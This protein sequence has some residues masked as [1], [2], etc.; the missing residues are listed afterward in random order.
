MKGDMIIP[1]DPETAHWGY[2]DPARPAVAWIEPGQEMRMETVS[3]GEA[4]LPPEPMTVLPAHREIIRK[5][6]RRMEPGHIL[7]VWS[8]W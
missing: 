2:F 1:A 5:V 8:W 4:M 7:C 6:T 3:G